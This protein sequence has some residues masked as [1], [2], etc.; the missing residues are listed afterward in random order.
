MLMFISSEMRKKL[1]ELTQSL[2]THKPM[3]DTEKK[4]V[5]IREA[6]LFFKNIANIALANYS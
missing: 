3:A 4:R 5:A 6:F 2:G 1:F